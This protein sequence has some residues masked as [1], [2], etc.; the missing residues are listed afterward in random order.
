MCVEYKSDI[1]LWWDGLEENISV[2]PDKIMEDLRKVNLPLFV[3]K[4]KEKLCTCIGGSL[5]TTKIGNS[6]PCYGV[7]NATEGNKIGSVSFRKEYGLEYA[8]HA[9]GM[10]QGISS[11]NMVVE[12]GKNGM[13][14]TLGSGGMSLLQLKQSIKDIKSRI[15]GSPYVINLLHNPTDPELERQTV[16]L[17]LKNDVNIIE[18]AAFIKV[19]KEIVFYRVNGLSTG[20]NGKTDIK[21]RIIAKI[22]RREVA[23]EFLNSPPQHIVNSLLESGRITEEQALLSQKV[24]MA[25]DITVEADSGGHT[26]NM[27]FITIL[28]A[29]INQ[30]DVHIKSN[31]YDNEIRVGAGGGIGSPLSAFGAFMLG[32]DYI[33]TGTI[34]Q[35]S[36]EA[37]TSDKVK[38]MLHNADM[39][40]VTMAPSADM[41][42]QGAMVQVLKKGTMFPINAR[43]LYELYNKYDSIDSI[44]KDERHRLEERIFK[45]NIDDVWSDTVTY[46]E[47]KSKKLLDRALKD[48]KQKM[49][50][51]FR[52]YLGQSAKWAR[53]GDETRI[54]D[55]QIWCGQSIGEFNNW[56][57]GTS[58]EALE[59]R[60]VSSIGKEIMNEVAFHFREKHYFTIQNMLSGD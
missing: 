35:T 37:G 13:L 26:D 33:V 7:I 29:I 14:G 52:W 3:V 4:W 15:N 42:E 50:L 18:C 23:E 20:K 41:F 24:S 2:S 19:S 31:V 40:D 28:P 34:N 9:G 55:Y 48:E 30:R 8:Y 25:D 12:L 57:K 56:V 1:N 47:T 27:P 53:Q 38:S 21:N 45:K 10:A 54:Y 59:G 46:L 39:A 32:A 36:A 58:L 60:K 5:S 43:K 17:L 49:A 6:L 51:I 44:P 22:S 11:V 16:D